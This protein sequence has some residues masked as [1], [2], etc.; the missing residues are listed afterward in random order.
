MSNRLF[1]GNLSFRTL[2]DSLRAAFSQNG[3]VT[4]VRLMLDRETGRSRGFAFVDMATA[5]AA[6]AAI[7]QWNGA[8]LDG[9]A[10]RVNPAEDRR[11]GGGGGGGFGGGG[12]GGRGGGGGFGGGGGGRG[13]G[14]GGGGGGRG[15]GGGFG[16]GGGGRGGGGAGGPG[17]GRGRRD[18]ESPW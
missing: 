4:G 15:G 3:E 13:G 7:Q 1:V 12:G 6:E 11:E 5:E 8:E 17:G 16:G 2:E 9:R 18:D 14:F 10:L